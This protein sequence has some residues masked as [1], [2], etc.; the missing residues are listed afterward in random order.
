MI[1]GHSKEC[2]KKDE[3][4][5]EN[6][7]QLSIESYK[8][9]DYKNHLINYLNQNSF[10]NF[11]QF[12]KKAKEFFA[13]QKFNINLHKSTLSNIYY[14]W[15]RNAPI[16]KWTMIFENSK[17]KDNNTFLQNYCYTILYDNNKK[18][19][20]E[21][22]HFIYMSDFFIN[23]LKNAKHFY[24]DGTFVIPNDFMQ[25]I[26]ILYYDE[27]LNKKYPGAYLGLNNKSEISYIKAFLEFKNILTNYGKD[28]LALLSYTTDFE[29]ALMNACEYVFGVDIKPVGCLF[30]FG[31]SLIRKMRKNG[32][33]R[34]IYRDISDELYKSLILI[35][36]LYH[37]NNNIVSETFSRF[38]EA[39]SD[40][41]FKNLLNNYY[42]YFINEWELFFKNGRLNYYNITK[43]QRSNS[44]IENYNRHI[45]LSLRP[46]V[47]KKGITTLSRP[48][49]IGFLINEESLYKKDIIERL[50]K[51]N[52]RLNCIRLN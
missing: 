40:K 4:F 26:I 2:I 5:D 10:I 30:H 24:I 25:V 41:E 43:I 32:M 27:E 17:T 37:K 49:F 31:Q 12:E 20:F 15:K 33:F 11:P 23:R 1:K 38:I 19:F 44:Y 42:N 14:S 28:N 48:I 47:N 8:F 45:K 36:W 3:P 35:P 29:K 7:R 52:I 9:S 16:F 39:Q 21:H 13:Q 18:K 50:N 22:K 51:K 34:D 6:I 46:F